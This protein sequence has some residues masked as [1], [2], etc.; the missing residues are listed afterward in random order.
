VAPVK[1]VKYG[2]VGGGRGLYNRYTHAMEEKS[3]SSEVV[4]L[5]LLSIPKDT[6]IFHMNET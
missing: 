5:F 6:R 3:F 1:W 2:A 4:K